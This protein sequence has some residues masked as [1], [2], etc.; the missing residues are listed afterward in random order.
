M[1]PYDLYIKQ[2]VEISQAEFLD[3]HRKLLKTLSSNDRKSEL[4]E[5]RE[6]YGELKDALGEKAVRGLREPSQL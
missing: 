4:A 5:Y 3:E 2:A 1:G 6:Q